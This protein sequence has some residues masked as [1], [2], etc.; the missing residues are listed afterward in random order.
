MESTSPSW[1]ARAKTALHSTTT[2]TITRFTHLSRTI[3]SKSTTGFRPLPVTLFTLVTYLSLF[4]ALIWTDRRVPDVASRSELD[5]WGVSVDEAFKDLEFLTRTHHPYNSR[6]N[7]GVREYLLARI[8]QILSENGVGGFNGSDLVQLGD[9]YHGTVELINDGADSTKGSNATFFQDRLGSTVYFEGTNI[10]VYIHGERP[11]SELSP[12]LVN[13]H[14]DSVSTAPGATDDG[15]GIVSVLQ[16]V[17]SFTRSE[18]KGGKR[19]QRGLIALFNNGEED[20]LHGAHAFA[21]HPLGRLPHMLLNLEGAGAGGRATLFRSN[22]SAVTRFYQKGK[23]PFGTAM[24]NDGWKLGLVRSDTDNS[25]FHRYLGMRGLDVAF[26]K[27]RSRYHNIDDD[28]KHTSKGSIWHMLGGSLYTLRAMVDDTSSE[29]DQN[30]GPGKGK[31]GVWFDL[32]GQK[33]VVFDLETLFIWTIVLIVIPSCVVAGGIYVNRGKLPTIRGVSR[34]PVALVLASGLSMIAALLIHK[35]NPMIVY[36][37]SDSVW[38]TVLAVWWTVSWLILRGADAIR[39]TALARGYAC[40]EMFMFWFVGMIAVAYGSSS[41]VG[42]A[43]GYWVPIFYLGAF[44]ASCISLYEVSVLRRRDGQEPSNTTGHLSISSTENAIPST[45]GSAPRASHDGDDSPATETT[46]LFRSTIDTSARFRHIRSSIPPPKDEDIYGSEESWSKDLPTWTWIPQF[47][48]AVPLQIIF[49]GQIS[50]LLTAALEQ[51]GCDGGNTAVPYMI[52][53]VFATVLLLPIAPFLHRVTHHVTI[54]LIVVLVATG[55]Y[56]LT[57]FP[58]SSSARIK[59]FFKQSVDLRTGE[60]LVH[61]IGNPAFVERAINSIPS[62][63]TGGLHCAP[64]TEYARYQTQ[65]RCS[66]RGPAPNVAPTVPGAAGNGTAA[67]LEHSVTKLRDGEALVSLKGANTRACRLFFDN[68]NITDV[69]V[70]NGRGAPGQRAPRLGNPIPEMGSRQVRLWSREWGRGWDVE[71]SWG[72]GIRE[73]G[74][75]KDEKGG[76]GGKG[77]LEGRIVCLWSDVN[78]RGAIP[79]YEELMT[80]LPAWAVITKVDDGLVEGWVPFSV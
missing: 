76:K 16:I 6:S 64:E 65:T 73:K 69:E 61:V 18:A 77:T 42:L 74:V 50:L 49:S 5:R 48:F 19:L 33:M 55:L 17:K 40:V 23:R 80:H 78:E 71:V 24:S 14:Y 26:Y 67:W 30:G 53:A 41:G 37:S 34:F 63:A 2:R 60:N 57:A 20:G 45:P 58:F 3:S 54:A 52:I 32:F 59:L 11:A 13:A 46:P 29:F 35:V 66:W 56:N 39:P 15:V 79:A 22:D 21:A 8:Q 51:T 31:P 68:R 10:M 44:L 9:R 1:T 38:A 28:M 43:S 70:R 7:D 4:T 75:E 36:S 27:P 72:G 12:A 62:A 47:L 25:F